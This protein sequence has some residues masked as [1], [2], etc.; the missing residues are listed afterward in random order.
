MASERDPGQLVVCFFDD[1]D[2]GRA[3][4]R[5]AAEAGAR[6]RNIGLLSRGV[7]AEIETSQL[8]RSRGGGSEGVGAMLS[9]IATA[10][11]GRV[12]PTRHHF[13]DADS[14]LTTDDIV[15]LGV[16]VD[17]GHAA[18]LVLED[19]DRAER[20][21]VRLT[22]I[23]G[24]AESHRITDSAVQIAGKRV[25]PPRSGTNRSVSR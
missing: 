20:V 1:A 23:G 16:E 7:G 2:T 21:I 11:T 8:G 12:M 17:A 3:A 10:I 15:R 22:E 25:R 19:R 18:V 9:L 4:A 24:K 6:R 14:E 13:L 5:A